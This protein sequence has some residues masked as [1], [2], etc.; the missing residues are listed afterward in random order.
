[1]TIPS[2]DELER[3]GMVASELAAARGDSSDCE[4]D[5]WNSGSTEAGAGEVYVL[6]I[7][8]QMARQAARDI[9]R[10]GLEC[11]VID[12]LPFAMART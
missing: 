9:R 3:R 2:G 7:A 12:G 1:M 11:K 6:S 5:F 8:K 10:A 4:F